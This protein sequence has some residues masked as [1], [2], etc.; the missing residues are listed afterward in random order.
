[1]THLMC[2]LTRFLMARLSGNTLSENGQ[3][4]VPAF[5]ITLQRLATAWK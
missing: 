3:S 2:Y 1:M 4:Y 5:P